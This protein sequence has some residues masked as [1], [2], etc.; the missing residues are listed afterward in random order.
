MEQETECCTCKTVGTF[1]AELIRMNQ[2][3]SESKKCV[4]EKE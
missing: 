2:R 1:H 4:L 3:V